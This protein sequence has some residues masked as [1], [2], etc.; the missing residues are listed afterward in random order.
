[1]GLMRQFLKSGHDTSS[2]QGSVSVTGTVMPDRALGGEV[3]EIIIS[4]RE[5]RSAG[6]VSHSQPQSGYLPPLPYS[7]YPSVGVMQYGSSPL[8]PMSDP[9]T[10]CGETTRRKRGDMR[11]K[12]RPPA[13]PPRASSSARPTGPLGSATKPIVIEEDR[14][15]PKVD[16]LVDKLQLDDDAVKEIVALL[17]QVRQQYQGLKPD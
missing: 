10:V 4:L 14:Q 11:R 16:F 5:N 2:E 17:A 9:I 12:S 3:V 8:P 7:S 6:F 15:L 1:M 13:P